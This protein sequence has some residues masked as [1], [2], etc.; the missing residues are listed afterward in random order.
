MHFLDIYIQIDFSLQ[1]ILDKLMLL[2]DAMTFAQLGIMHPGIISPANFILEL[3]NIR[4]KY[5]FIPVV[6]IN[7]ENIH[8]IERSV[9]VKVYS[10][11]HSLTF[12]LEIPSV[13]PIPLDLIHMFSVPNKQN[14]SIIPKSKYLALGNDEYSYLEEDARHITD[15]I[16]LSK[17]PNSR[18]T[19]NA[20]DCILSLI[21][22]KKANCTR[23]KVETNQGKIQELSSNSWLVIANDHE[24]ITTKCGH[25][26]EYRRISGTQIITLTSDCQALIWNKTLQTHTETISM[27]DVIPL[28]NESLIKDTP[29]RY[30]VH[31]EDVSLDGIQNAIAKAREIQ[32]DSENYYDWPTIMATPSWTTLLL[33]GIGI[34]LITRKLYIW[35]PQRI[36]K[37]QKSEDALESGKMRFRPEEGGVNM[38]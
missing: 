32:I 34:A 14:L 25:K 35:F 20:E 28:P 21:Q 11:D 4:D 1:I 16:R 24:T 17:L 5:S 8:R 15:A 19:R 18:S 9:N 12:I 3:L 2:E 27:H 6:A 10:T 7:I 30:Q 36:Q 26:S 37:Q 23:I 31:L 38:A 33:Y 22:H 29:I 13:D